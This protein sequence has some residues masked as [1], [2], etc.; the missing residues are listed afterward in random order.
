MNIVLI[1]YR[2]TGKTTV[3]R[4]LSERL[5]IPFLDTDGLA[6]R[7][8][9]RTIREIVEQG[10]WEGFRQMEKEVI[11]GVSSRTGAVIAVGGGAVMDPEN[12]EALGRHGL[13]VWLTADAETIAQR[14]KEDTSS[15]R[16]RPPL[17]GHSL[18]REIRE[19]LDGR[20]PIYRQLADIAVDTVGRAP[21]SIVAEL[22]RWLRFSGFPWLG[23]K[24][25]KE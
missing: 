23:E 4:Q 25:R 21:D 17:S 1:G 16:Q 11:R 14:M 13:F 3:G 9:G 10:G 15:P 5:G 19:L 18:Q 20:S 12:R 7:H 6:E 22:F 8:S 24:P 2:C